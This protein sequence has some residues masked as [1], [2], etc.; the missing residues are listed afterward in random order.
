MSE[1]ET[2]ADDGPDGLVPVPGWLDP[3]TCPTCAGIIAGPVAAG[4]YR[5]FRPIL[6]PSSTRHYVHSDRLAW[7]VCGRDASKW[8]LHTRGPIS[9]STDTSSV[10]L[11]RNAR[12]E[13]QVEVRVATPDC[14]TGTVEEAAERASRIY[15]DLAELYVVAP[16]AAKTETIRRSRY[17]GTRRSQ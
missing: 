16:Q 14:I 2:T 3:P 13:V 7:A 8:R 6:S 15:A 11:T 4:F 10:K 9:E 17:A 1:P 5:D 12:G